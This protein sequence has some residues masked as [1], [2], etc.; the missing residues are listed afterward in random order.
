MRDYDSASESTTVPSSTEE[1]APVN[2][3]T[4]A[5][6]ESAPAPVE[7]AKTETVK[8]VVEKPKA[9]EHKAKSKDVKTVGIHSTKNLHVGSSSIKVGYNIVSEAAAEKWLKFK[10]VRKATPEEIKTAY[11]K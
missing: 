11:G 9:S 4:N 7:E 5:V 1:V 3:I 2:V 8:P 10:A 6:V